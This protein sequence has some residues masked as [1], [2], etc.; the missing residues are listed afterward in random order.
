[1]LLFDE[2][3]KPVYQEKNLALGATG[4]KQTQPTYIWRQVRESNAGHTDGKGPL[5]PP[6]PPLLPNVT[7]MLNETR[8]CISLLLRQRTAFV[9]R[10]HDPPFPHWV[11]EGPLIWYPR[12][13]ENEQVDP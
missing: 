13:Q 2:R 9:C 12:A 11:D 7:V 8:K 10:L 6:V 3:G 4:E 5:S 1:M